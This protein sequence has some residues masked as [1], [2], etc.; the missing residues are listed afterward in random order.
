MARNVWGDG[1][2]RLLSLPDKHVISINRDSFHFAARDRHFLTFPAR[3]ESARAFPTPS[4]K[5]HSLPRKLT[6][7]GATTS[8]QLKVIYK[9][10]FIY[11]LTNILQYL[12]FVG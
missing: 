11:F 9:L 7:Q 5:L 1:S 6:V 3:G 2:G 10:N 4:L 8:E 12:F